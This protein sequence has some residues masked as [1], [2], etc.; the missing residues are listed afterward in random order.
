MYRTVFLFSSFLKLRELFIVFVRTF[1]ML[2]VSYKLSNRS[3]VA[4]KI[5][6]RRNQIFF[7][8]IILTTLYIAVLRNYFI[9]LALILNQFLLFSF[10]LSAFL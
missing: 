1:A 7:Q 10:N 3:G 4:E 2:S 5:K 9:A 8:I 6:E